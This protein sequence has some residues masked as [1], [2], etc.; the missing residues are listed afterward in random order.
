MSTTTAAPAD[1]AQLVDPLKKVEEIKEQM[2]NDRVIPKQTHWEDTIW[3]GPIQFISK[4]SGAITSSVGNIAGKVS[5]VAGGAVHSAQE[6][7][8]HGPGFHFPKMGGEP[9][10][11][12]VEKKTAN[13]VTEWLEKH[14][15]IAYKDS[16]AAAQ[17]DGVSL[18]GLWEIWSVDKLG[19]LK[20]AQESLKVTA[21]GHALRLGV[22]LEEIHSFMWSDDIEAK[23]KEAKEKALAASAQS[24]PAAAPAKAS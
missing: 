13:H 6:S 5:E 2:V 19:F 17:V 1:N 11:A 12:R 22:K 4:N 21:P 18:I 9:W 7:L 8:N 24:P 3:N 20:Y 16:F 10:R 23:E 14:Q 15:L